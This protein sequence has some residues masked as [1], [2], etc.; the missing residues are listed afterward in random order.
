MT[1]SKLNSYVKERFGEDLYDFIKQKIEVEALYDYEIASILNLSKTS[2]RK[3][4]SGFGI[5]KANGF[6]RRF[7]SVYGKG[8]V[9]LFKE[10]IENPES[11]LADVARHFGFS[12]EYA[13]QVYRKIYG[14]SYT[15]AHKSK[16]LAKKGK[17]LSDK[18]RNSGQLE[19]L[20]KVRKKMKSLGL[21][22]TVM[23]KGRSYIILNNGYKLALRATSKP[24][25]IGKK[26]YFKIN[27]EKCTNGYFDFFICLC[28]N[29]K[30]DIHYVIPSNVMPRSS[31]SLLTQTSPNQSKYAQFEEAWHLLGH[32]EAK[33]RQ[34]LNVSAL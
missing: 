4:R 16:L 26:Q 18:R 23:I 24:V 29:Q 2:F 13:R 7:E 30:E 5:K 28:R 20:M 31:V 1:K 3:L 15:V 11:S 25:K 34:G 14:C 6:S 22:A 12:R 19:N 17:R 8:S 32:K 27:N 21:D 33:G 9:A 10:I